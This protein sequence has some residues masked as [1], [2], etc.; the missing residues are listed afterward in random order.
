[1]IVFGV[2][3]TYLNDVTGKA[4]EGYG[5]VNFPATEY[6]RLL[7]FCKENKIAIVRQY[8]YVIDEPN[9]FYMSLILAGTNAETQMLIKLMFS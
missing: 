2:E 6:D 8:P 3:N 7:E 4:I 9:V 1:M 5:I